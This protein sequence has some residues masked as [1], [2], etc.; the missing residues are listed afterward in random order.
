MR[1][2]ID[3]EALSEAIRDYFVG[4]IE[5]HQ[6]EVDVVDCNA[7]IQALLSKQPSVGGQNNAVRIHES[8]E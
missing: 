6:Y 1:K 5:K 3:A 4:L 2:A 7:D 8:N